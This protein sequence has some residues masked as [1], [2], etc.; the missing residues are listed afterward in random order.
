[1]CTS[2]CEPQDVHF[3]RTLFILVRFFPA[4]MGI[5][6]ARKSLD[7]IETTSDSGLRRQVYVRFDIQRR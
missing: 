1:M 7:Q 4:L 2:S 3:G 6:R 5:D